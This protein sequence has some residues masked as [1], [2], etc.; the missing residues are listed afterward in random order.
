MGL[1]SRTYFAGRDPAMRISTNLLA[2]GCQWGAEQI[3]RIEVAAYVAA[4]YAALHQ[5]ANRLMHLR[6][7]GFVAGTTQLGD[8]LSLLYRQDQIA[9]SVFA[10]MLT[11]KWNGTVFAP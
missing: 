1:N 9:G 11:W 4:L 5:C 7:G 3:N 10:A 2:L 8:E 6:V